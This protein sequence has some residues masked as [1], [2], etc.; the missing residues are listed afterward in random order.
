MRENLEKM[1]E[2]SQRVGVSYQEARAALEEAEGDV[3]AAVAIAERDRETA[4]AGI[5]AAGQAF[6]DELKRLLS[7]GPIRALRLKFGG[8]TIKEFS[9][10]TETAVAMLLVAALAIIVT[11]MRIEVVRAPESEST[12]AVE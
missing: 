6:V 8:R 1:E 3:A 4:G 2:V 12:L 10:S 9:V 5:S 7:G 11:K